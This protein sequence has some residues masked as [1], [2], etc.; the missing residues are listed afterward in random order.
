MAAAE[1]C[2]GSAQGLGSICWTCSPRKLQVGKLHLVNAW[3]NFPLGLWFCC[4]VGLIQQIVRE[5]WNWKKAKINTYHG[6]RACTEG[7]AEDR[8]LFLLCL[9]RSAGLVLFPH[10]SGAPGSCTGSFHC[11]LVRDLGT[12]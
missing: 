7:M 11:F 10:T 12:V 3:N 8:R 9:G 5:T 1:Q 2:L 6:S 4:Q